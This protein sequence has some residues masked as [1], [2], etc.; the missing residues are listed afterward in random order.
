MRPRSGFNP[1]RRIASD[2]AVT[3]EQRV[4]LAGRCQ[5]SGSPVHKRNPRDYG[6][7]GPTSPRPGKTLCDAAGQFL[8]ADSERLLREG[9]TKGMVSVQQWNGW[10][11]NVWAVS[12]AGEA[13]EAQ[14]EN[15]E[16]G[17]YH[18]YPLQFDDDFRV[19]ILEEWNRR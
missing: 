16:Q 8:K 5:Y 7:P 3:E 6:L 10:P 19:K 18:G 9:F 4:D 1:K 17:I 2:D 14:L 12:A 15:R 13:F 11:Q